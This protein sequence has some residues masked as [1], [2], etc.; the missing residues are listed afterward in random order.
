[1]EGRSEEDALRARS[2]RALERSLWG[3]AEVMADV[4]HDP[5]EVARIADAMRRLSP[6]QRE[7]LLAVRLEDRTYAEIGARMG[8]SVAQVERLFAASLSGLLRNLDQPS[9][10]W[11][12]RWWGRER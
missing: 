12:R 9:R 5:A 4:R 2:R 1:M 7:V 10:H 6:M 3:R 11:W 8:L